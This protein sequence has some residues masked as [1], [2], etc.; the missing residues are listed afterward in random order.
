MDFSLSGRERDFQAGI[1]A[2]MNNHVRPQLATCACRLESCDSRK[3]FETFERPKEKTQDVGPR[4]LSMPPPSALAQIDD[5]FILTAEPLTN[6]EYPPCAEEIGRIA[7]ASG[8]FDCSVSDIG[9][10]EVLH[11]HGTCRQRDCWL[12]PLIEGKIRSSLLMTEP[13]AASSDV[14]NI[15]KSIRRD[16]D[17]YTL[18]GG[19]GGPRSEVFRP[20]R[21]L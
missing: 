7:S 20:A 15:R 11:S 17:H 1:A 13:D 2:S 18:N 21:L 16:S 6:L 12:K 14:T 10:M 3:P 8:V 9:N 19:N 5:G 4:D